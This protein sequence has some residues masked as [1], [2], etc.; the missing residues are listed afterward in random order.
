MLEVRAAM[1]DNQGAAGH[2]GELKRLCALV[3]PEGVVPIPAQVF[4]ARQQRPRTDLSME[5]CKARHAA[6][7]LR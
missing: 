1:A 4:A 6:A 2:E 5:V 3:H 7:Q